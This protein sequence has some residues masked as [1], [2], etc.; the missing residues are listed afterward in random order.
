MYFCDMRLALVYTLLIVLLNPAFI[1][2]QQRMNCDEWDYE[3][4][5]DLLPDDSIPFS[6]TMPGS[7]LMNNAQ[8]AFCP[9]GIERSSPDDVNKRHHFEWTVKY[10]N[11]YLRTSQGL[12]FEGMNKHGFSA[13]LMF[14][15]N[16]RLPEKDKEHIP[17]A[18][19]LSINFFID[20]FKCIDTAL[21]AIWDIR[22]FDDLD[23]ECGWPFRL[24]LHDSTGATAYIEYV[25]GDLRVYTPG[26]P[27]LIVGGTTYARL[28]TLKHFPDSIPAGKAEKRFLDIITNSI[29]DISWA[30][31]QY[32]NESNS[33]HYYGILRDHMNKEIL[34]MNPS[35][36][37]LR[38]K[39][40]EIDFTPGRETTKKI[41]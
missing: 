23:L 28:I 11:I 4:G 7:G 27:A 25:M 13:S 19:S 14:L 31:L 8:I 9:S 38:L 22:I 3:S 18:A 24:I 17:I 20:H 21:L 36:E 32:Y 35:V 1:H 30:L 5:T 37:E 39:F 16:S 41:F 40:S 34:I 29:P 10:N 2:A 15:K 26:S 6:I 33:D 12:V